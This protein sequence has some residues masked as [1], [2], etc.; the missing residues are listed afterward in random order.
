MFCPIER[1]ADAVVRCRV[2]QAHRCPTEEGVMGRWVFINPR[3]H[4]GNPARPLH[5]VPYQEL[6]HTYHSSSRT[7]LLVR[8]I[9][10]SNSKVCPGRGNGSVPRCNVRLKQQDIYMV[11]GVVGESLAGI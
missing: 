9:K 4:K 2:Q 8:I 1:V 6:C 5:V 3:Q 7:L 10:D 11:C